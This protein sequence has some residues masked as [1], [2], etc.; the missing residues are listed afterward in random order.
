MKKF[1]KR[2]L[3]LILCLCLLLT[4]QAGM[5]LAKYVT[6]LTRILTLSTGFSV[7]VP[8]E[9]PDFDPDMPVV[10]GLADFG[11]D[12][13]SSGSDAPNSIY[14]NCGGEANWED[15]ADKYKGKYTKIVIGYWSPHYGYPGYGEVVNRAGLKI[16]DG[17]NVSAI[18]DSCLKDDHTHTYK[19]AEGN[20]VKFGRLES[21]LRAYIVG[22]TCYILVLDNYPHIVLSKKDY[23]RLGGDSDYGIT[24]LT[25]HIRA[26]H[27]A[28]GDANPDLFG[29]DSTLEYADVRGLDLQMHTAIH[30]LFTG[31][32]NIQTVILGSDLGNG[33]C[34]YKNGKWSNST[35]SFSE[36]FKDCTSLTSVTMPADLFYGTYTGYVT[37]EQDASSS[38]QQEGMRRAVS[39]VSGMFSGCTSLETIS[40]YGMDLTSITNM[41]QMFRGCSSLQQVDF[42]GITLPKG[43]VDTTNMFRGCDE[44]EILYDEGVYAPT[45]P[46]P[47]YV[48]N[49]DDVTDMTFTETLTEEGLQLRL[50]PNEGFAM[51]E[52][53]FITIGDKDYF[54]YTTEGGPENPEGITFDPE[55]SILFISRPLLPIDGSQIVLSANALEVPQEAEPAEETTEPEEEATEPTEEVTEPTEETIEPAEEP[56]E[57]AVT[58][59]DQTEPQQTLGNT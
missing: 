25:I 23:Q 37:N 58:E 55:E 40:F 21:P 10:A 39:N 57:P 13:G 3:P 33:K 18:K 47:D 17:I 59:P 56:V 2:I 41:S 30:K 36:M 52:C 26:Y 45:A 12:L 7:E 35:V 48:L 24:H 4:G 11:H 1:K 42:R 28:S 27:E 20:T 53:V 44:H 46:E 29:G 54:I 16:D 50:T 49:T 32:K 6:S 43:G 8:P 5:S 14:S 19:D 34:T 31:N 9:F 22:D 38:A 51:P 15:F